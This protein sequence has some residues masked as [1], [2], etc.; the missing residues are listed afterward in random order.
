M[1]FL[2]L[3]I[4]LIE[5]TFLGPFLLKSVDDNTELNQT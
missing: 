5:R 3:L 1:V 4:N 2:Q